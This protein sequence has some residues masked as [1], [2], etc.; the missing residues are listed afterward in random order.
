M[1]EIETI[2]EELKPMHFD[3]VHSNTSVMDFGGYISR[4]LGI[5]HI[6][7]LRDF[8][9]LDYNLHSIWGNLYSKATYRNGDVFIAISNEIKRYFEKDILRKCG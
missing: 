5:K 8:G 1:K 7:H 2:A 3:L 4:K 9:D 6:W